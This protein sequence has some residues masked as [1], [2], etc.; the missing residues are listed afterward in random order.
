MT[1]RAETRAALRLR[2]ND[3][4]S[5]PLWSDPA[6]D[7]AL[8][9]ALRRYGAAFPKAQTLLVSVSAG[10]QWIALGANA[11]DPARI[12]RVADPTGVAIP[13]Q[14]ERDPNPAGQCWRAWAD[15]LALTRPARGGLWRIDHRTTRAAPTDDA[16]PLDLLPGDEPLVLAWAL[17]ALLE[18]RAVSDAV[19]GAPARDGVAVLAAAAWRDAAALL[20]ARRRRA[21]MAT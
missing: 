10:A 11:V 18:S 9:D 17:A 2:L 13:R 12:L 15:G 4:G 8:T 3:A 16:A 1:T 21:R 5:P 20:A 14:D 7:A 6:L 19:R